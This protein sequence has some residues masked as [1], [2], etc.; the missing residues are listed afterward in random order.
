D[1]TASRAPT[2]SRRPS[3]AVARRRACRRW[4][5]DARRY[6][7]TQRVGAF[8]VS[9]GGSHGIA[10]RAD[11]AYV[12]RRQGKRCFTLKV[13]ALLILAGFS[14]KSSLPNSKPAKHGRYSALTAA[15]RARCCTL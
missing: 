9:G 11:P 8:A 2:G 4:V 3:L 15:A 13:C 1:R 14:S 12:S 7:C 6:R 5:P 10:R